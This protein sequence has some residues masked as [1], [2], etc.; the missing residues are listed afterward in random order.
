MSVPGGFVISR[1]GNRLFLYRHIMTSVTVEFQ[2]SFMLDSS[3][4]AEK[5]QI[6]PVH[7]ESLEIELNRN[8]NESKT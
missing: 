6:V 4:S 3:N 8:S 5:P 2:L 1:T 7:F